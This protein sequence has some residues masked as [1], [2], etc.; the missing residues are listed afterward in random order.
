MKFIKNTEEELQIFDT[1]KDKINEKGYEILSIDF[2]ETSRNITIDVY[3]NDNISIDSIAVL[4]KDIYSIIEQIPF[5][6]NDFQLELGSPG[7]NRS[8]KTEREIEIL[9]N[10]EVIITLNDKQKLK[11]K[12]CNFKN[13]IL[14]VDNN[15]NLQEIN[16]NDIKKITLNG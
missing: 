6:D 15:G 10:K 9:S 1:I 16:I 13:D 5:L 2:N 12:I 7:I 3:S 14:T 8:I 11:S 4:S